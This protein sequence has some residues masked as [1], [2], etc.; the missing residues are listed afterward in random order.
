MSPLA[1]IS[2]AN[3]IISMPPTDYMAIL[4]ELLLIGTGLTIL[5]LIA[6]RR[7]PNTTWYALL[8]IAGTAGSAVAAVFNWDD[9]IENGGRLEWSGMVAVDGFGVFVAILTCIV[10][11]LSIAISDAY[12]KREGLDKAEYYILM[13]FSAAGV[14]FMAVSN[15][16]IMIFL[17]LE[18]LSVCLYVLAAFNR[19]RLRSQEAGMKY[20]LLGSFSSA[21][22]LYG[23]AMLYGGTGTA[24]LAA[25]AQFFSQTALENTGMVV[26]GVLFIV[27]GLGFKIGAVPFHMWV[28]DVYEGSPAPVVAYMAAAAKVAGFAALFRILITA[29]DTLRL[30]W[31][32]IIWVLAV[33]T[34]LI[35]SVLAMVQRNMKRLMAYSSIT[36][37]GFILIGVVAASPDGIRGSLFYLFSYSF[38][39]IGAFTVVMLIAGRGEQF[40]SLADYRGLF[41]REPILAGILTYFLFA[42]AGLPGTSGFVAKFS[43][44]T[45]AAEAGQWVI[46]AIGAVASVLTLVFYIRVMMIMYAHDPPEGTYE[47][48]DGGALVVERIRVPLAA[49]FVLAVTVG[50]TIFWG[51][52]PQSLFEFTG[53]AT[54]SF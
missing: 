23:I 2:E 19:D 35:A 27:V 41:A 11:V 39:M 10:L 31:Q 25:I 33:L 47:V 34:M 4:P 1:Q 7:T 17:S 48:T 22:L 6:I 12:L 50:A 36:T 46:V 28:P 8:A 54:L 44:L 42:L 21:I 51:I 52:L 38:M 26:L 37:A 20:L 49:Q 45:A 13:L 18:L 40:Q 30:D 53:S 9:I 43:V 29:V 15:N 16:L 32:P 24:N 5:A 14:Q 3:E